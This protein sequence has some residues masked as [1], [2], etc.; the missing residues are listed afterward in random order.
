MMK[1]LAFACASAMFVL[2]TSQ[3]QIANCPFNVSETVPTGA[4]N[5]LQ[6]SMVLMRYARGTRG[7][8]LVAGTTLSQTTVET[9]IANNFAR[10]DVNGNGLID[11][12]DAAIVSRMGFSFT[13]DRWFVPR[14]TGSNSGTAG[15]GF[16]LASDFSTRNTQAGVQSFLN[17][18]CAL[19]SWGSPTT[20]QLTAQ[21]EASRFLI[22]STFGPSR[23]DIASFMA[24]PL[25]GTVSGSDLK[26]R[27]ST[28]INNQFVLTRPQTH[29][30]Y[31]LIRKAEYEAAAQNFYSELAREAF[32][33]QALKNNDQLRQRVAFALSQV[34][35]VSSNGGSGD[36]FE[37][38]AYLD[39]LADNA[40]G[41]YKDILKK[42]ALSP[43]MG[44]YLSH[45]RND[46]R[47]ATPN[48][49][50]ARE[51]LQLFSVG[52]FRLNKNG[53]KILNSGNPIAAYTEDTVKGF[54]RVFTGFAH[55]DP[56][57]KQNDPGWAIPLSSCADGY[58]DTHPSWFW[59]PN[60]DD[61]GPNFPPVIGG[62][63]RSM[64]AFPGRH[65][66]LSKQLLVYN[67]ADYP[68]AISVASCANAITLASA[69]TDP[70]LLPAINT[71]GSGVT[72]GTKVNTTQ[73]MQSIDAAID[74][75]FCHPNVAP[76]VA[77]HFIK[78]FVTSNPTPA[79]VSR[80]ASTFENNGSGVRGDMRAVIRAVLL[81]DEAISSGTT[82]AVADQ[83]KFGKLREPMLRLS[84]I[85]RAFNGTAL[86][87]KYKWHYG[88]DSVEYGIS[89]APLQSPTVF[90]YYHPEF[91]PPGPVAQANAVGPEFEITT[92]TAIASTQNFFGSMATAS[93]GNR[94]YRQSGFTDLGDCDTNTNVVA[95]CVFSDLS[96]LYAIH[97]NTTQLFDYINLVLL[98]GTLSSTN[99]DA[100]VAALDAAYPNTTLSATP[101]ASNVVSWQDRR[102]DRVKAALWLA[103]HT[104]EFQVQR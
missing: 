30:Q 46:G 95:D 55:D 59:D 58:G 20:P 83:V 97:A 77:K 35:V 17:A 18:G 33:K 71:T 37:L 65:S 8:A 11:E 9:N 44:N 86:S 23:N 49:N 76:F 102:R 64:A 2:A 81:D 93:P 22:R 36:P 41:N 75:I 29:F 84:A 52:L 45:L 25:D 12:D 82:L 54:A 48:E 13:A 7:A 68:G 43:A 99:R 91:A 104:P 42:V 103:V 51:I 87:G 89:Q 96:E 67:Y 50:F 72:T 14:V 47:S 70:G 60:R 6:D 40:F 90:N 10:L 4:P 53:E 92:T 66:A 94:L 101:T 28:W 85:T 3:A 74:N 34:L 38:M 19:Y 57:C 5:A 88:L 32:W 62:W 61:L 27:A 63:A 69:A 78:F 73:A 21:H 98:G 79:Y 100:L 15:T 16:A 80:V 24:L 39:L 31:G 56:Y 26:R 1:R